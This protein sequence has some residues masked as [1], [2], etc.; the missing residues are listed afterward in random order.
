MTDENKKSFLG[1]FEN[2]K[3]DAQNMGACWSMRR[4]DLE[5]SNPEITSP[6]KEVFDLIDRLQS[7][8]LSTIDFD[9]LRVFTEAVNSMEVEIDLSLIPEC[10]EESLQALRDMAKNMG[11]LPIAIR[12]YPQWVGVNSEPW[13]HGEVYLTFSVEE[14]RRYLMY[15]LIAGGFPSG[16]SHV[17]P[18]RYIPEDPIRTI[19]FLN[20]NMN[21]IPTSYHEIVDRCPN[22]GDP[23]NLDTDLDDEDYCN[24]CRSPK[25]ISL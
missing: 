16:V 4:K 2:Y 8:G 20:I 13:A 1:G 11:I 12:D 15:G 19:G 6:F 10:T 5:E 7:Q 22:C 24:N 17:F 18:N 23:I 21:G 3:S 25:Y 9:T 14:G